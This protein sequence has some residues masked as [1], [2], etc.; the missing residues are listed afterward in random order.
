MEVTSVKI[1]RIIQ[2]PKKMLVA[3]ASVIIDGMLVIND[4][5]ILKSE[6][7][8]FIAMPSRQLDDGV[9][10][11]M[12]HPINKEGR[13]ILEEAVLNAYSLYMEN[14]EA[15]TETADAK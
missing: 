15:A 10:R 11:D 5:R 2:E 14:L 4:I 6:E 9:Y 12:V 13:R 8:M 7:K 1:Q 3:V